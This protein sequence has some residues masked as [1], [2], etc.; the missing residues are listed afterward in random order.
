MTL[1]LAILL[2]AAAPPAETGGKELFDRASAEYERGQYAAALEDFASAYERDRIPGFLFNMGQCYRELGQWQRAADLFSR[3]L[4]AKPDAKNAALVRDL[5]DEAETKA[6]QETEVRLHALQM[7]LAPAPAAAVTAAT[8]TRRSSGVGWGLTGGGGA[9]ALTG[10]VLGGLALGNGDR[11]STGLDNGVAV[12]DH[13]STL[14]AANATN[15]LATASVVLLSVGAVALAGGIV[16][17]VT[18]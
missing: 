1:A 15:S 2:L 8:G 10:A 11:T 17:L 6:A 12:T 4:E 7:G 9:V 3:Y 14:A 16:W 13:S 5:R 18:R